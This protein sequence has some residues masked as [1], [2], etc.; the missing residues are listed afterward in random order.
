MTLA[1][2]IR[3]LSIWH[4]FPLSRHAICPSRSTL[5]PIARVAFLIVL[6]SG[7]LSPTVVVFLSPF[8]FF[9]LLLV[10]CRETDERQSSNAIHHVA[11]EFSRTIGCQRGLVI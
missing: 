9:S 10:Y 3:A 5:P 1:L 4:F 6:F 2:P 11:S 7:L 8:F